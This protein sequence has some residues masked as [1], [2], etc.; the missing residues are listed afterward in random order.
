MTEQNRRIEDKRAEGELQWSEA[1]GTA[2]ARTDASQPVGEPDNWPDFIKGCGY[3]E[4]APG[5]FAK[6][7]AAP[8]SADSP[9]TAGAAKG[10]ITN[11][12]IDAIARKY[13]GLGGIEDYR[14][15]ARDLLAAPAAQEPTPTAAEVRT[16]VARAIWNIRREDEDRCDMELEDMG[17]EH[18]VWAEADAAIRALRTV[19]KEGGAA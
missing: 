10:G 3:T 19:S 6:P 15:F 14:S 9:S 7:P 8:A 2:S 1:Q 18:S 5:R 17:D 12:E 4:T 16:T 13:A 11:E